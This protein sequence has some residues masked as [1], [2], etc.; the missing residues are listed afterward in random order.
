MGL[1]EG[2]EFA[3]RVGAAVAVGV[4]ILAIVGAVINRVAM[5]EDRPEGR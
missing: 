3:I 1:M 4:V 2:F 5:H